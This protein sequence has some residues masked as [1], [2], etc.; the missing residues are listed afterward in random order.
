M[1]HLNMI[2]FISL[3]A[4]IFVGCQS[5]S[6]TQDQGITAPTEEEIDEFT[7]AAEKMADIL[8]PKSASLSFV[9]DGVT[10]AIKTKDVQTTIF[11]FATYKPVNEEEGDREE[12]TL[13]WLQGTDANRPTTVIRFAVVLKRQP[14]NGTYTATD[15]SLDLKSDGKTIYYTVKKLT[16]NISGL[17][18]KKFSEEVSGYS[19]D[20]TFSGTIADF[21]PKGKEYSVSE[22]TYHLQY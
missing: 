1:K 7:D 2:L 11:P 18:K 15:G 5:K 12:Q 16:V 10:Y 21:G 4:L 22:G 6:K 19:L 9:M 3:T 13:I 20:M 14:A 17:T 8:T